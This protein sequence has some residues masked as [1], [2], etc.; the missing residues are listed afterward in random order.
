MIFKEDVANRIK[1]RMKELNLRQKDIV[2]KA[3][4]SKAAMSNY[5]SASR[6]PDTETI[7]KLSIILNTSIEWLLV[8]KHTNENFLSEN[9]KEMLENFKLLPERE[10]IKFIG[11][12]EDTAAPYKEPSEKSSESKTG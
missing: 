5:L 12:L 9:E 7:Y 3:N 8:G 11:R 2:D 10:Q 6:L 4:I 1:L